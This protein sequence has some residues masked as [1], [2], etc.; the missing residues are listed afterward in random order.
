MSQKQSKLPRRKFLDLL[1]DAD[2][3]FP[4][5]DDARERL[6]GLSGIA[7]MS[8]ASLAILLTPRISGAPSIANGMLYYK[9]WRRIRKL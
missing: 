2:P 5:V 9:C 4:E 6:V 1:K 7:R 8:V 3:G